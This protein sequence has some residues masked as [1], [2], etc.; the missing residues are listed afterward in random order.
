MAHATLQH[1]ARY[2]IGKRPAASR[3]MEP[4]KRRKATDMLRRS[5]DALVSNCCQTATVGFG[6]PRQ[7]LSETVKLGASERT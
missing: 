4:T 2:C 5:L 7:R 3:T 6:E 1:T